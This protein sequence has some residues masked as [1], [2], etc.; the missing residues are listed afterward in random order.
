MEWGSELVRCP[1]GVWEMRWVMHI[2]F[3]VKEVEKMALRSIRGSPEK[4]R[5]RSQQKR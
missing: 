3:G 2:S 1:H 4:E 5:G